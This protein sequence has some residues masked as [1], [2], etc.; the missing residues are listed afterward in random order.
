MVEPQVRTT[1]RIQGMANPT[2]GDKRKLKKFARYLIERPRL[3]SK[4][5]Y[6][7]DI[8]EVEGGQ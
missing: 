1:L 2:V 6:Q 7:R 3:V 4:F 5:V 8:L